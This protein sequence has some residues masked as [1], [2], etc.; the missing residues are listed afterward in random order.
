MRLKRVD[1]TY[2]THV[3]RN[4]KPCGFGKA[5]WTFTQELTVRML[6]YLRKLAFS[7]SLRGHGPF[8]HFIPG[9]RAPSRPHWSCW[10]ERCHQNVNHD[11]WRKS[12]LLLVC[13]MRS[14]SKFDLQLAGMAWTL[15][16]SEDGAA[17]RSI[18]SWTVI[19]YT[20]L[21]WVCWYVSCEVWTETQTCDIKNLIDPGWN[22]QATQLQAARE[23]ENHLTPIFDLFLTL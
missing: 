1:H 14:S 13:W 7:E 19:R 17:G 11:S 18:V 22:L 6:Q 9:L 3:Q 15:L 8:D 21:V 12:N 5:A 20:F 16:T 4:G 2:W 10:S 23:N